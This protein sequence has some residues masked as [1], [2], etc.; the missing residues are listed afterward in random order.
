M[1]F[2]RKVKR[3]ESGALCRDWL[4]L[5]CFLFLSLDILKIS[6]NVFKYDKWFHLMQSFHFLAAHHFDKD[7][8]LHPKATYTRTFQSYYL[9]L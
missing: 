5:G 9:P 6:I 7:K 4:R 3:S 8:C 1:G 2:Y